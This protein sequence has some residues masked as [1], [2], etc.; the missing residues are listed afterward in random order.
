MAASKAKETKFFFEMATF[1]YT[2]DSLILFH[3]ICG[4]YQLF[5]DSLLAV[6]VEC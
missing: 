3:V 5:G 2:V 4:T 1:P 6:R